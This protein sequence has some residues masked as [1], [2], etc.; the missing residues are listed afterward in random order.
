MK[1]ASLWFGVGLEDYL[2]CLTCFM[3]VKIWKGY[4]FLIQ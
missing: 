3:V 4:G 2:Q 1:Q